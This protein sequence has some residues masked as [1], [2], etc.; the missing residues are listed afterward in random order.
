MD[1]KKLSVIT[2]SITP[3]DAKGALDEAAFRA[4]IRRLRD[5][6]VSIFVGGSGS[7]EGYSLT[8]EEND[9][10]LA[11]AV[12]EFKGKAGIYADGVEPH[13]TREMVNYVR[14]I[15]NSRVDAVRIMPLD[16]GHG[17]KPTSAELEKYHATI[18]EA[19]SNPIMLTSHQSAGY[20]LPF[21]LIEKLAD[22]YPSVEAINYGGN[23]TTYLAELIRRMSGRLVVHCAGCTNGLVS[24]T[25]GGNGFMGTEGNIAPALMA[26]VIDAYQ[27]N[28]KP[29]LRENF[30]KVMALAG[31]VKKFG[32]SSLRGLKP[33]LA[34]FGLPGGSLREPRLP[35][36][37]AEVD[38]MVK[39]VAALQLPELPQPPA[40]KR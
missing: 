4:H 13:T 24:L 31:I 29:R 18:I 23:D 12:E 26:S 10:I 9:R 34:A 1:K 6:G 28:D 21:D 3:F 11:I 7:G 22:R 32:G 16:T 25:L 2:I 35:L 14:R 40:A 17:S 5:G 27:A 15:E 39:A 37:P 38:K 36:E 19:T 33:M 8:P 30:G 20:V